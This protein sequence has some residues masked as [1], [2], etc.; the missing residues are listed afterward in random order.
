MTLLGAMTLLYTMTV[1]EYN[2]ALNEI[3][4]LFD[5]NKTLCI[6][7]NYVGI[8]NSNLLQLFN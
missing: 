7:I 4:S 3:S 6:V 5:R 2:P 1:V 8:S